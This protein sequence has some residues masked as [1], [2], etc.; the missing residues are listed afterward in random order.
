MTLLDIINKQAAVTTVTAKPSANPMAKVDATATNRLLPWIVGRKPQPKP[1][2]T[3][4][5]K[6][7]YFATDSLG[8]NSFGTQLL[9]KARQNIISRPTPIAQ[10]RNYGPQGWGFS[11]KS[12]RSIVDNIGRMG[13]GDRAA[14]AG[15]KA[16]EGVG[17]AAA[18]AGMAGTGG[19]ALPVASI[20]APAVGA[21]ISMLGPENSP[22]LAQTI[23][24]IPRGIYNSVA[25]PISAMYDYSKAQSND[26]NIFNKYITMGMRDQARA[27]YPDL[28][29][30]QFGG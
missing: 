4:Q 10:Q 9:N 20:A 16:L 14:W 5:A 26:Q 30:S 19:L 6:S 15:S 29:R 13:W 27:A 1:T 17:W 3:G 2:L 22:S 7:A 21:G 25:D 18:G 28:Y 23:G 8:Y 12:Y 11:D 24:I